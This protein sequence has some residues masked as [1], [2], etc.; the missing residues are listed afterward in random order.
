MCIVNYNCF[1]V[2]LDTRNFNVECGLESA[3]LDS[4][5]Y[6][7]MPQFEAVSL[8]ISWFAAVGR[9]KKEAGW[10]KSRQ[11]NLNK[12]GP[13]SLHNCNSTHPHEAINYIDSP[14]NIYDRTGTILWN[15]RSGGLQWT[16]WNYKIAEAAHTFLDES[17]KNTQLKQ[18][19]AATTKSV[20][21]L[22]TA[23][24]R[25]GWAAGNL[26]NKKKVVA[27]LEIGLCN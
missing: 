19:T 3:M 6:K 24:V 5:G 23:L 16:T 26:Q 10:G 17:Y 11:E 15:S 21:V 9:G 27:N 7:Q 1:S 18:S 2:S 8:R 13:S 14:G 25:M 12:T 20:H 4:P 22:T